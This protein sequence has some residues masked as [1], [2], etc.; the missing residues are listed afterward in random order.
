M[1]GLEAVYAREKSHQMKFLFVH[2]FKLV[3]EEGSKLYFEL[4]KRATEFG[5][6]K[7]GFR[8]YPINEK[9][10]HRMDFAY[11]RWIQS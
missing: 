1:L 6:I 8:V 9:L 3:K 5:H 11:M 7:I 4:K 10:P 2:P